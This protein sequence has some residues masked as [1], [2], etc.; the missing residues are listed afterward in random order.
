MNFGKMSKKSRNAVKKSRNAVHHPNVST[1]SSSSSSSSTGPVTSF[2]SNSG[3][4]PVS[5]FS[6]ILKIEW[7][8]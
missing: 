3:I 8:D 7:K 6:A 2:V 1:V 4:A 5:L